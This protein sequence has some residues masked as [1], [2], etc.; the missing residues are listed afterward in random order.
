MGI[1]EIGGPEGE[2]LLHEVVDSCISDSKPYFHPWR[3]GDLVLWDNWRTLHCSTGIPVGETR[4]MHRTT[5]SGSY[6]F[7]QALDRRTPGLEYIDV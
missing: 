6:P 3:M 5:I 1:Y 2:A 4:V 7:G